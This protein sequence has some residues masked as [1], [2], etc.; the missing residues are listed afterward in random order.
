M[1]EVRIQMY[2]GEQPRGAQAQEQAE[3]F[4]QLQQ[5]GISIHCTRL[6]AGQEAEEGPVAEFLAVVGAA[7][8]PLTLVDGEAVVSGRTPA[9]EELAIWL[10]TGSGSCADCGECRGEQSGCGQC[11]GCKGEQSGCG[12]CGGCREARNG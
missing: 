7:G 5:R 4:R 8:L 1:E 6:A 9:F 2:I 11:G 12:Q 10:G 3:L